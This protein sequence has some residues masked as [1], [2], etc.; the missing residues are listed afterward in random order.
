M[1]TN[2]THARRQLPWW[3]RWA[4]AAL[5]LFAS[6]IAMGQANRNFDHV[7]TGFPLTGVHANERCESCHLNGVFKGTPRDCSTCHTTGSRWARSNVV[8][9]CEACHGTQSFSGAKFSHGAVQVGTCTTCHN[10]NIATGKPSGHLQTNASCDSCHKTAGWRPASG[11]DH[12]GV[13]PGS[14]ATCHNGS[15]APGKHA[16]HMPVAG[17]VGCDSCHRSFSAWKPTA[18]NHTQVTVANQCSTCHS[19]AFP[20]ADGKPATH[21]PYQLVSATAAANCDTC[22][23]AGYAA[24]T[25]ARLH[26]GVNVSTQCAT[27]HAS[28]KPNTTIHNGQTVCE[29]CHKSTTDWKTAKVDHGTYTTAT[30][31]TTCHNGSSATGKSSTHAPVGNTNCVSCHSVNTW[32][33]TTFNHTQVPVANQCSTCHS[34]AFPP[35]DGRSAN[36]IP[37][38]ALSGVAIT[39]CDTCHKAGYAAWAPAKFHGAVSLSTQ[40]ASCHSGSFPPAVGKPNTTIHNGV[41][42]CESCHKST[43]T[44]AGAKVDHST[45]TAATNCTT[46]HNG[47]AATGKS[48]T[49]VPVA[50]TNCASCHSVSTWRPTSFNHTQV[51]VTNQ[52]SNCHNGA[53]PPADGRNATHIPYQ[54]LSGVA[55]TNCDSCHK[56]GYAAWAPA[57]FHSAV[58]LSTQCASCHTGS[59]P[60]AVGKPNT[61][62]HN[63]VTVC[64]SCHKSTATWAGAKVDHGT[65]TA[66]TNCGTCHNGSAATGKPATHVPVAATNCVNCH[67]VTAWR[68]TKWNHT[69][70]TVTNQCSSC[71][72]GAYPP[73]DGRNVT[74]IPYQT[75]SGVAITNCDTCHKAGY[76]AWAPARFHATVSVSTQ[77]ATCH[78]GTYAPAVGK[79]NT[80]VHVGVTVCE[81][82]HKST[83]SWTT[84]SF[85]HSAANAVGTGTC[86]NCHNGTTAKGKPATHIPVTTGATKC[87]SCHKSQASW[88]TSVTMN[89][90]VVAASTC[91]SCHNGSY[92]SQGTTGALAKPTNHI[93]EGTQLLNGA[94]MDCN[95]CHKSTTTWGTM[96]MNHNGSLGGGAGWCKGC[97]ATGTN[98]LGSM[99]KKSPTHRTKT[100]PAIDCSESG[101]HRP[102]G[103][104]GTAYSKWD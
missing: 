44:W 11:F 24:W 34:G 97:H 94:A 22:H 69:Q 30:N 96:T 68:P 46:C 35:A 3:Q 59:F 75:L 57:R 83:A 95:S 52:C 85:A 58:S 62:I 54:T 9:P 6:S 84:V 29:T 32:K 19:G 90:T 87:D 40:C 25:P 80:A 71:H 42:V 66:A 78:T 73:A 55:I 98:Y 104:R 37:Y 16:Q 51:T 72:S 63:G 74:H 91:K 26:S 103:T 49:H 41:T 14:C 70:V 27:C 100:P 4:I 101:C 67:N 102:L 65:F 2:R 10:G 64:E 47:S 56:A 93:P 7:K 13:T 45:F 17:N 48:A 31:C 61:T 81:S 33:P 53:F 36:H 43:A 82:C 23:K 77:C 18:W 12:S 21:T 8:M 5:M 88:A 15:R 86:D 99:E 28:A 1:T 79:P 39:N 20:P 60:P 50:A 89:H 76:A 92:V 38:Q